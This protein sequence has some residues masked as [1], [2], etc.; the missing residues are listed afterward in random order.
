[1]GSTP[2][3]EHLEVVIKALKEQSLLH[4][5]MHRQAQYL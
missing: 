2:C 3:W 5:N 1:M 4:Y